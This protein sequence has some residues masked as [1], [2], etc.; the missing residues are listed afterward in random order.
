MICAYCGDPA[1]T[2]DHIYP[3]SQ[4]AFTRHYNG[5]YGPWCGS[6]RDCNA[7]FADRYFSSF[8][9]RCEW[10]K[11]R[12]NKLA[13]AIRWKQRDI[14]GLNYE[15]NALVKASQMKKRWLRYR[16]DWYESRDYY[17]NLEPLIWKLQEIEP[18]TEGNCFVLAFFAQTVRDIAEIYRPNRLDRW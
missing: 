3:V 13:K 18:T 10:Q 1:S 16:A 2:R 11:W 12:L 4:Q 8:V 7:H 15:L 9:D 14:K 17:L 5:K 6:C